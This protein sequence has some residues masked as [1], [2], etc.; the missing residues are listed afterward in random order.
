MAIMKIAHSGCK[1]ADCVRLIAVCGG[2]TMLLARLKAEYSEEIRVVAC[3]TLAD[4]MRQ[5][6]DPQ[7]GQPL[8]E[9]ASLALLNDLLVVQLPGIRAASAKLLWQLAYR[10]FNANIVASGCV[11]WLSR[12]LHAL[13]T[14]LIKV[15]RCNQLVGKSRQMWLSPSCGRLLHAKFV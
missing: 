5:A 14:L 12:P 8:V 15:S 10:N 3:Q 2:V 6:E 1:F 11:P 4:L 7:V 13:F 9:D